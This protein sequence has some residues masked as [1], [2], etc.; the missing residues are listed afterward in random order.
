LPKSPSFSASER[1]GEMVSTPP[2]SELVRTIN[3][4]SS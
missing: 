1:V 3:R 2:Y 4:G